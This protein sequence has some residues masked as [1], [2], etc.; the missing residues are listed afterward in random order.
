MVE[1]KKRTKMKKILISCVVA[2]MCV[3][4]NAQKE[5]QMEEVQALYI[6]NFARYIGW[7]TE[8]VSKELVVTVVGNKALAYELSQ[9]AA[10]KLVGRRKVVVKEVR[11]VSEVGVTDIVYVGTTKSSQM[12]ELLTAMQ[13]KKTLIVCGKSGMCSNGAAIA[14]SLEGS[15]LNFQ[16]SNKNIK[17]AG[18]AVSQKLLQLGKAVN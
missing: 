16:I 18:L 10:T 17:N 1:N 4:V 12:A 8:D 9:M 13:G 5:A 14:F 7:P 2:L 11:N 3:C 6:Y 15:K